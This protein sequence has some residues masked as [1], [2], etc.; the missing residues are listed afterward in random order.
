M[1][2]FS[3]ASLNPGVIILI[4]G[5]AAIKVIAITMNSEIIIRLIIE[6]TFLC[7]VSG[8]FLYLIMIGMKA[9]L[10]A[11]VMSISKTKSGRRNE[12]KKISSCFWKMIF[13]VRDSIRSMTFSFLL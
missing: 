4:I 11:P 5:S 3:W 10:R 13:L 7:S 12:A 1:T 2:F 9:A 6:E 8:F